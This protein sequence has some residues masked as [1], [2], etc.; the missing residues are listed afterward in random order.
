MASLQCNAERSEIVGIEPWQYNQYMFDMGAITFN[1]RTF[2]IACGLIRARSLKAVCQIRYVYSGCGHQALC[3]LYR[4][5]IMLLKA[6][7]WSEE[8]NC[9]WK[10]AKFWITYMLYRLFQ[11]KFTK[12]IY[13]GQLGGPQSY[14]ICSLM[15]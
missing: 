5:I 7:I 4:R 12:M 2:C 10:E 11:G 9:V 3:K 13:V 8:I 6:R 14:Y 1:T 15:Q